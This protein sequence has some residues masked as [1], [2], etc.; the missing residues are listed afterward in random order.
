MTY[1]FWP[2]TS[3][4]EA[5]ILALKQRMA[6]I[7]GPPATGKTRTAAFLIATVLR[8]KLK[9]DEE[10]EAGYDGYSEAVKNDDGNI[11]TLRISAVTHSNGA[12]DVLLEALLQINVPA[13]RAGRPASVAPSVQHC[14]I[15]AL[16][17]CMPEVIMSGQQARNVTLDERTR[18]AAAKDA[19]RYVKDIQTMI[20]KSAPV[21]VTSCIGAQQL[22]SCLGDEDVAFLPWR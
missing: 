6:L 19:Q 21:V 10:I 14:T 16:S 3:Q 12:A 22:L 8:L 1:L 20:S 18:H 15:A 4:R 2:N 17:E 7:R 9:P 5:I 13:V 11:V